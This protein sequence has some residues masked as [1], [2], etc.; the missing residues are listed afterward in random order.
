[1]GPTGYDKAAADQKADD[2]FL[3]LLKKLISQK[4]DVSPNKS[5]IYAPAVFSRHPDSCGLTSGAF[6]AAMERLLA[7]GKIK[8]EIL[9]P[10]S[11]EKKRLVLGEGCGDA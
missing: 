1:M 3:D 7:A 11:R 2:V 5:P 9:G 8:V 6:M 10:P 4:R